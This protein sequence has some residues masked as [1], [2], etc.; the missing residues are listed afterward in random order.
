MKTFI[1]E[2]DELINKHKK[3]IEDFLSC[4][5]NQKLKDR[6][7]KRLQNDAYS[8]QTKIKLF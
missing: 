5:T 3:E 1:E 4:P 7:R 8:K 2:F 6:M